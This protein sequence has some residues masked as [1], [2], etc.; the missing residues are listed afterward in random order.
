MNPSSKE[1]HQV[2]FNRIDTFASIMMPQ[3]FTTEFAPFHKEIFDLWDSDAEYV[4]LVMPRGWGKT[5]LLQMLMMREGLYQ[6]SNF[7]LF[8]S[9][10]NDQAEEK[11]EAMKEEFATNESVLEFFGEQFNK[12]HWLK[13]DFTINSGTTYK[14]R[15]AG[16]S[17]RGI[18]KRNHRPDLIIIDDLENDENVGTAQQREK[19]H[20]WFY[21]TLL[22]TAIRSGKRV[23]L[24][25]RR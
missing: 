9:D 11:L 17:M 4:M 20:K 7:T 19:L 16:Q 15:G 24:A 25:R 13:G 12:K 6:R 5:T 18:K 3:Y 2:L 8:I 1:L 21:A 10:T 14:C 23:R 22:P